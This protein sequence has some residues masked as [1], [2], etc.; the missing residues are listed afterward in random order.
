MTIRISIRRLTLLFLVIALAFVPLNYFLRAVEQL[1]DYLTYDPQ[2]FLF[3]LDVD[4]ETT[5]PTWYSTLLL[6][7]AGLLLAVIAHI[8]READYRWHWRLLALLFTVLS[9]DELT[10]IHERLMHPMRGALYKFG[11]YES[12]LY[13]AWVV[14]AAL[15]IV[16]LAVLYIRFF[17]ALPRRTLWLFVLAAAIFIGGALGLELLGGHF[18]Y[19]DGITNR[20]FRMLQPIEELGEMVGLTVFI[21]AL[22]EYIRELAPD[23]SV[24]LA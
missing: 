3:L 17:F 12:Y 10:S 13:F 21:Y 22:L 20:T 23:L 8:R 18:V 11:L 19:S 5:I 9:I 4:G 7:I 1:P 2:Q 6:A 24:Q 15:G 14:P 16:V